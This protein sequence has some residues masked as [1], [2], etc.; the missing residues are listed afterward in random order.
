[1]Q[2]PIP[3]AKEL[4]AMSKKVETIESSLTVKDCPFFATRVVGQTLVDKVFV[5]PTASFSFQTH[6]LVSHILNQTPFEE[7]P[8]FPDSATIYETGAKMSNPYASVHQKTHF[9]VTDE[10]HICFSTQQFERKEYP[11]PGYI[12]K[13]EID[14]WLLVERPASGLETLVIEHDPRT[15]SFSDARKVILAR[16]REWERNLPEDIEAAIAS[17]SLGKLKPHSIS[18]PRFCLPEALPQ[19][20]FMEA[21]AFAHSLSDAGTLANWNSIDG[22][23]ALLHNP[24]NAK[25]RGVQTRFEP[26]E[27]LLDWWGFTPQIEAIENELR[28]LGFDD[29]ILFHVVLSAIL[30]TD[31]ARWTVS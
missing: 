31:K 12:L 7:K 8:A 15:L 29:V 20:T 1:M 9:F 18:S 26:N 2:T 27:L 10:G 11:Y 4:L 25:R 19:R 24:P 13:P 14:I 22:V 23:L 21:H 30:H 17:M 6:Q 5:V 3:S 16:N 28:K